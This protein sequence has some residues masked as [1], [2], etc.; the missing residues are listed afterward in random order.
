MEIEANIPAKGWARIEVSNGLI[1]SI[2]MLGG[3][4]DDQPYIAP[5]LVD[6]QV[7]GFAGVDFSDPNLTWE[8]AAAVLPRIW[9][10]GVTSFCPT[11]ITNTQER[12]R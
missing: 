11:L 8:S 10:T 12:L 7:N 5:G 9:Q 4:V 3:T 1:E 6:I 2:A